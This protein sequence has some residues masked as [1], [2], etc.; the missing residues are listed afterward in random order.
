MRRREPTLDPA[1]AAEL[2]ALEAA[3]DAL[4][5]TRAERLLHHRRLG[6]H[7]AY[8]RGELG[9]GGGVARERGLQRLELGGDGGIEGGLTTAHGRPPGV[10]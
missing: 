2:E 5:Q 6:A 9:L 10:G 4:I 3:L 1:V 8:E 7:V